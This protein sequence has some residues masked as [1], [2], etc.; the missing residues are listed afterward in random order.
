MRILIIQPGIGSYRVDFLNALAK[1]AELKVIYFYDHSSGQTFTNSPVDQLIDCKVE[2]LDGGFDL[3]GYYPIR[4]GIRKAIEEFAPDV[5][6][7]HEYNTITLQVW[8]CHRLAKKRWKLFIWTSDSAQMAL[9]CRGLRRLARDFF[10]KRADAVMVYSDPVAEAYRKVT[11][12]PPEKITVCTNIQSATKLRS[13]AQIALP[14]AQEIYKKLKLE[15]KKVF[16]FIGRLS[17]V[18]NLPMLFRAFAVAAP[19]D[20]ILLIVGSGEL[21]T[22][23]EQLRGDLKMESRIVMC[24]RAE[25]LN[26]SAYYNLAETLVLPS[27][28]EPFGAVVNEALAVG[29]R[30]ILTEIAGAKVLIT[31]N[32]QG[33]LINP[34][35]QKS[36]ESAIEAEAREMAPSFP[37]TLRTNLLTCDLPECVDNFMDFCNRSLSES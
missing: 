15:S 30:V 7:S 28:S 13:N 12:L 31:S 34:Q 4:P 32:L 23:L 27:L 36:L 11:T 5:V 33:R 24:G 17:P 37:S 18:K 29:L 8:L 22:E 3:R 25:G 21:E 9:A 6:V 19:S 10:C 2:K 26:L 14:L 20:A 35:S 16:L 1:K